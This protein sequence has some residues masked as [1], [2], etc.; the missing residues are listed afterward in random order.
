[1][2]FARR[3]DTAQ[4]TRNAPFPTQSPLAFIRITNIPFHLEEPG[5]DG[6]VILQWILKKWN[7]EASTGFI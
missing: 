3:T 7:W 4:E 1:M 5:V 2:A 6:R